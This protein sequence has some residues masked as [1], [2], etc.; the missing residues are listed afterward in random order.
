MRVLY[1]RKSPS[2]KAE[3]EE[4]ESNLREDLQVL[5]NDVSDSNDIA[6]AISNIRKELSTSKERAAWALQVLCFRRRSSR[7]R[8]VLISFPEHRREV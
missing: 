6:A 5:S 8:P 1:L 4:C 3:H 7:L 2:D